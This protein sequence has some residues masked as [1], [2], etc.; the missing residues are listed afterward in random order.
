[1]RASAKDKQQRERLCRYLLRPPLSNDRLSRLPDGRY[2][3]RLKKPWSDGTVAQISSG[4]ELLARLVVLV[5]PPKVHTVRYYGVFAPRSRLRR[6][7]VPETAPTA[8]RAERRHAGGKDG[9]SSRDS[10]QARRRRMSWASLLRLVF[11]YVIDYSS[12]WRSARTGSRYAS[13]SPAARAR[14]GSRRPARSVG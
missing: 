6:L 3:L 11:D 13:L 8:D 10:A 14:A 1:V 9:P 2:S 4:E 5:P 7:I 12:P